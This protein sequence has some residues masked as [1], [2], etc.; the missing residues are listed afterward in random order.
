MNPIAELFGATPVPSHRDPNSWLKVRRSNNDAVALC[1]TT[2]SSLDDDS[3]RHSVEAH[4][5]VVPDDEDG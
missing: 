2:M 3:R 4:L 5:G 1:W